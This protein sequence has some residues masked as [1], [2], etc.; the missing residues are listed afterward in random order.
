[1]DTIYQEI[2]DADQ[3]GNGVPALRPEEPTDDKIGYVVVD[4]PAAAAD[5]EHRVLQKV[6]IPDHKRRTY[7]LC[8]KLF[9]N[10]ALLRG[11]GEDVKPEEVQEELDFIDAILDTPPIQAAKQHL[12]TSLNL[13]ISQA[14]LASMIKETWFDMGS[15]GNQRDASGFEHVFVGEQASQAS[16]VGGYHFWYKYHLD[17]GGRI[18]GPADGDDRIIYH[19]E[20]Y[21]GG[22]VSD[23][24]ILVPE[25]VTLSL[26]WQAPDRDGDWRGKEADQTDRRLF[27]RLQPGGPDRARLSPLPHPK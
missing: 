21:G 6:N 1:M 2:W 5:P 23:Q 8:Q 27:R 3:R 12:A 7:Q 11:A 24:G 13:H 10:Y 20:R 4:E 22:Q 18:F 9:D 17:D 14:L 19:G 15:A 16:H 25:V 26:T